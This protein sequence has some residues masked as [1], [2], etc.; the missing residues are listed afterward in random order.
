LKITETL[1][2]FSLSSPLTL[3]LS[4]FY[5]FILFYLSFVYIKMNFS[6][7]CIFDK[8]IKEPHFKKSKY[9]EDLSASFAIN[10]KDEQLGAQ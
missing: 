7:G 5:L 4:P 6:C 1:C 8:K 2:F 3:S 9:F 10:A